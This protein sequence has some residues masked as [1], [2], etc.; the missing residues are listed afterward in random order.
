MQLSVCSCLAVDQQ[1]NE[2]EDE[3]DECNKQQQL[4]LKAGP[5]QNDGHLLLQ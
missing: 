5:A 2:N 3:N 4:A 1:G